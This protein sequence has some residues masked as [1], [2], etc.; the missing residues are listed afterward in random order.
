M[1]DEIRVKHG[2]E[3]IEK[4]INDYCMEDVFEHDIHL[5]KTIDIDGKEVVICYD[6]FCEVHGMGLSIE[7]DKATLVGVFESYDK[8]KQ[9]YKSKGY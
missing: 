4:A 2:L 8:L 6:V 7:Y 9:Y 5:Y 3:Y 1:T